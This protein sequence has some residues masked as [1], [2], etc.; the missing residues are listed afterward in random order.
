MAV[1]C[2]NRG[3]GKTSV[4]GRGPD[5]AE[6]VRDASFPAAGGNCLVAADL[7]ASGSPAGSLAVILNRGERW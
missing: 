3:I 1:P 5:T 4:A 6:D 2:L 7:V